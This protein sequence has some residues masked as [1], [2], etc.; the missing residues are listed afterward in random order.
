[1]KIVSSLKNLTAESYAFMLSLAGWLPFAALTILILLAG[2]YQLWS[3]TLINYGCIILSFL[4]GVQWGI[5]ITVKDATSRLN[6]VVLTLSVLPPLAAW[7][8]LSTNFT[9]GTQ[10][11]II[12]FLFIMMSVIDIFLVMNK[13]IDSWFLKLRCVISLLV[14]ATLI[15]AR[16]H[17]S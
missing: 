2:Q 14:V 1:M 11:N 9:I 16:Y 3:Y 12:I 8:L 6:K 7:M 15:I 4:G 5:A 17:I 13:L 10:L